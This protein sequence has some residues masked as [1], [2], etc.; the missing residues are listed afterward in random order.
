MSTTVSIATITLQA[1]E[2]PSAI[3]FGSLQRMAVHDMPGGGRVIDVLGGSSGEITF[4]GILSGSNAEERAYLLDA[5]CVSGVTVP[6][7]WGQHYFMVV[8]AQANFDYQKS[9]W[10]PYRLRC[11]VSTDLFNAAVTATTSV[12][13]RILLS[14]AS[15]GSL[16]DPIPAGLQ[17]AQTSLTQ[18]GATVPGTAAFASGVNNLAAAQSDL[19]SSVANS[20]ATLPSFDLSLAG[21]APAAAILDIANTTNAA[22][23]LASASAASAYVG[24]GLSTLSS[25]GV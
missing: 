9:W 21:Q 3:N 11:V 22:G 5:I 24:S 20:G 1:F 19:A 13:S 23:A 8:V 12:A 14:L 6:L 17:S 4:G 25:L 16:L 10:I 7:I 18:P 2:V 15:A